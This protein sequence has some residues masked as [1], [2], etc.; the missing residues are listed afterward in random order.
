M[1]LSPKHRN[2]VANYL[3]GMTNADAY[4]EAGYKP[5]DVF[6][7]SAAANLLLK[8]IKIQEAVAAGEAKIR[9]DIDRLLLD[10]ARRAAEKQGQMIDYSPSQA[11]TAS[12]VKDALDRAGWKAAEKHEHSGEVGINLRDILK[13]SRDRNEGEE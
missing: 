4:K 2:F 5:K 12:M 6:S 10:N 11:A 7:A 3:K 13:A 8:N 9:D 1:K